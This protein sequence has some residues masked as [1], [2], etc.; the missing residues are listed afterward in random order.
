VRWGSS[1]DTDDAEG[2][3]VARSDV[4]PERAAIEAHLSRFIGEIMQVPPAFS[5]IKID[6][7]RAYDLARGGAQLALE[8]RVVVVDTLELISLPNRDCAVFEAQCGKGTYVRAIARDLGRSLG[9]LGHMTELRRTAVGS[10]DEETTVALAELEDA[11]REGDGALDEFLLPI[12]A[13]LGGLAVL[14]VERADAARLING[15]PV[16][17]RGRDAPIENTPAYATCKG[18]IIA[19]G[20]IEK[21]QLRPLRVFNFNAAG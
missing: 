18:N 21:G 16:L 9:C 11:A 8:P 14:R 4:R 5:A 15:Q 10:F 19:V 3:E 2:R 12:E 20:H 13:A 1:T 7:A 17:V 6:G